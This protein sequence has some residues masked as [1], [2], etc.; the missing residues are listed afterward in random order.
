[1]DSIPELEPQPEPEPVPEPEPELEPPEPPKAPKPAKKEPK[2]EPEPEPEPP[3]AK[4]GR[5]KKELGAPKAKYT[6]R[7]PKAPEVVREVVE[8]PVIR[9]PDEA[10]F[11]RQVASSIGQIQRGH[12]HA[13]RENWRTIVAEN[14]RS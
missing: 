5:P 6:P 14:Y 7:K 4:P 2:P 8:I 9:E 3:K 12:F 11:A 13:R 1:M 10:H